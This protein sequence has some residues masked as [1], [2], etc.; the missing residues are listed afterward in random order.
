MGANSEILSS[1]KLLKKEIKKIEILLEY[2]QKKKLIDKILDIKYAEQL[3]DEEE[4]SSEEEESSSE[5]EESDM[6][7]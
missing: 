6:E 5:E 7:D 4:S 1:L 3:S 2:K